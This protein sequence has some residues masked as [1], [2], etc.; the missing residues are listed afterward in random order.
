MSHRRTAPLFFSNS[1]SKQEQV[2]FLQLTMNSDLSDLKSIRRLK[3][4]V[5][6][7]F[8]YSKIIFSF[9][10]I[11]IMILRNFEHINK[12]TLF[13]LK[14]SAQSYKFPDLDVIF[15][16]CLSFYEVQTLCIVLSLGVISVIRAG[17]S[18]DVCLN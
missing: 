15:C 14:R 11:Y 4:K 10:R 17:F 1:T 2:F 18:A 5:M 13:W 9:A 12:F 7:V 8:Q 16:S 3:F 6:R